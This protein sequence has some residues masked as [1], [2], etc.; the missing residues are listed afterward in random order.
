MK[1]DKSRLSSSSS[2]IEPLKELIADSLEIIADTQI[3]EGIL[4]DLPVT[5]SFLKVYKVYTSIKEKIFFKKLNR[6]LSELKSISPEDKDQ[7]WNRYKENEE[8]KQKLGEQLII[9]LD[10]HDTIDKATLLARAFGAYMSNEIQKS[11]F[12]DLAMCIDSV[13][14]HNIEEITCI[15]ILAGDSGFY[16]T[17]NVA[18]DQKKFIPGMEGQQLL[19]FKDE[20]KIAKD[21]LGDS[22]IKTERKHRRT[23]LGQNIL[24]FVVPELHTKVLTKIREFHAEKIRVSQV[25]REKKREEEA[26]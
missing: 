13:Q 7:F 25:Y 26:K 10:R 19:E 24:D 22:T 8:E 23:T 18:T 2:F 6:F 11:D 17:I 15:L 4:K 14:I 5:G 12:L 9:Y 16:R 3:D 20:T 21:Y 1:R